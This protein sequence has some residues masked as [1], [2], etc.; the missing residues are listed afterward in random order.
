MSRLMVLIGWLL[1][2]LSLKSLSDAIFARF[3]GLSDAEYPVHRAIWVMCRE[4]RY[5]DARKLASAHW[6]RSKSLRIGRDL[7]HVL[8]RL[9]DYQKAIEVAERMAEKDTRSPWCRILAADLHR[10]FGNNEDKAL[11]MYL[12][13]VPACKAMLPYHYAVAVVYKRIIHIYRK[14]GDIPNLMAS[15]ETFLSVSPSNFRDDEFIELAEY[16]M[17]QGDREGAKKV[18][19]TSFEALRRC[20]TVREAYERMGFGEAPKVPPRKVPLPEITGVTRI[21]IPT[22]LITEAYGPVETVTRHAKDKVR[23]G[24]IVAL[25]SCVAAIL[26]GRMLMEGTVPISPIA[27]MVARYIAGAHHTGAFKSSAPMANP[28]SAQTAIEEIGTLRLLVAAAI[29]V[30]GKLFKIDGWFYVVSGEQVAQIDDILGSVPPYDY[31]VMMGARDACALSD[32]IAEALGAGVGAAIVDANDLGIAWA[33]GYSKGIDVK[34]LE[35]SLSDNPA[36]NQEQMTPIVIV[37]PEKQEESKRILTHR[38]KEN[39]RQ[40]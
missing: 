23:P 36:G 37:R 30:I 17:K 1:D 27:R 21:S 24:D 34:W 3:A 20:Y 35:R 28:L 5:E 11:Q 14:R 29:G 4:D 33:V 25:S 7:I 19:E 22:G 2:A 40:V 31:Y 10:F 13:V 12:D 15:L 18:L 26:E 9:G 32:K 6:D 39:S 16:K 38:Q 8:L